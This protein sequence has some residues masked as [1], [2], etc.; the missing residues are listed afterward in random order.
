MSLD[1]TRLTHPSEGA[2]GGGLTLPVPAAAGARAAC[3]RLT[4]AVPA[5]PPAKHGARKT[6]SLQPPPGPRGWIGIPQGGINTDHLPLQASFFLNKIVHF[7]S[8]RQ[9]FEKLAARADP[10]FPGARRRRRRRRI[11]VELARHR[12]RRLPLPGNRGEEPPHPNPAAA[13]PAAPSPARGRGVA[14]VVIFPLPPPRTRH[15]A[16]RCPLTVCPCRVPPPPSVAAGLHSYPRAR[17]SAG[18]YLAREAPGGPL[19][20]RGCASLSPHRRERP[21]PRRARARRGGDG[22]RT[23]SPLLGGSFTARPPATAPPP[24]VR[25]CPP[26]PPRGAAAPPLPLASS[27]S[28]FL[29]SVAPSSPP[30]RRSPRRAGTGS[31]ARAR[32]L[33]RLPTH[34]PP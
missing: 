7:S 23:V 27:L 22:G 4:C 16:G 24:P 25:P 33:P 17:R 18:P 32:A 9:N 14:G 6:A 5:A 21:P 8:K 34:H 12:R 26:R 1:S 31:G 10:A 3:V 13:V 2:E 28:R 29:R 19:A 11:P 15:I 20:E 30:S